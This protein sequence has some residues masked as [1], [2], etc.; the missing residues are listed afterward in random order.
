LG[1][2][3]EKETYISLSK[4]DDYRIEVLGEGIGSF[5]LNAESYIGDEKVSSLDF[6]NIPV[7]PTTQAS[8]TL[9]FDS[10]SN[11][12]S[13]STTLVMDIDSDGINDLSMKSGQTIDDKVYLKLLKKSVK[14]Y[15]RDEKRYSKW[16]DKMDKFIERLDKGKKNI[17]IKKIDREK[18]KIGHKI[19]SKLTNIE[20]DEL[21][22]TYEYF[23][24]SFE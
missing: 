17:K 24:D 4:D 23:I 13:T 19:S 11:I 8:T 10:T 22:K 18:F 9:H 16:Q 7:V 3:I 6:V 5:T 1:D 14:K 21:A 15:F 12:L 2:G 20:K